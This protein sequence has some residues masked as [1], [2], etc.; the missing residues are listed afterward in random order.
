MVTPAFM[1][2][3]AVCECA[4]VASN[5]IAE[6]AALV[7]NAAVMC[8]L[9]LM[10]L[11]SLV[12]LIFVPCRFVFLQGESIDLR[13][14]LPRTSKPTPSAYLQMR[15]FVSGESDSGKNLPTA[16]EAGKQA[17]FDTPGMYARGVI[18]LPRV[19]ISEAELEISLSAKTVSD[20]RARARLAARCEA[21]SLGVSVIG[22]ASNRG[23]RRRAATPRAMQAQIPQIDRRAWDP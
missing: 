5:A 13:Q 23:K 12:A 2:V 22:A 9:R 11:S 17:V 4:D 8:F 1:L 18:A 6:I 15:L 14:L 21:C 10:K 7:A 20:A 19:I 16:N 3:G